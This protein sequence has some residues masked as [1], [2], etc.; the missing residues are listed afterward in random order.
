MSANHAYA[1]LPAADSDTVDAH[2][3]CCVVDGRRAY[4]CLWYR[5]GREPFKGKH[6]A[7]VHVLRHMGYEK[8]FYCLTWWVDIAAYM[9][10]NSQRRSVQAVENLRPRTLPRGTKR[11]PPPARYIPATDGEFSFW[12][13]VFTPFDF[14]N[15]FKTFSRK[16]YRAFHQDKCTDTP[17]GPS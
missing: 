2:I 6:S 16:D 7:R 12:M 10:P 9:C 4:R 17:D 1:A 11:A 5:C 3:E 14:S 15:S 8:L 13:R